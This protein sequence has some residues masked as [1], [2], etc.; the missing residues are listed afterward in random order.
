MYDDLIELWLLNKISAWETVILLNY[1]YD[2]T[3][4][5][6]IKIMNSKMDDRMEY[7]E[8]ESNLYEQLGG[9]LNE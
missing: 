7:L 8:K 6:A 9:D 1:R 3:F 2:V 4:E 5:K